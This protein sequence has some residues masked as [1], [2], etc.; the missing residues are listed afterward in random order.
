MVTL[1][2]DGCCPSVTGN[3]QRGLVEL[4]YCSPEKK[5]KMLDLLR[6]SFS[7]DGRT[8]E[9]QIYTLHPLNLF[10]LSYFGFARPPSLFFLLSCP[11]HAVGLYVVALS[12]VAAPS[13]PWCEVW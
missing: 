7:A 10:D 9:F 2:P 11:S 8:G 13:R 12:A 5:S 1:D 3:K 6:F 4:V